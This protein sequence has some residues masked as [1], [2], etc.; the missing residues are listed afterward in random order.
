M[1]TDEKRID[2]KVAEL[3]AQAYRR[4]A[5]DIH[6]EPVKDGF[7]VRLRIDG[8]MQLVPD[9]EIEM[10]PGLVKRVMM[11]SALN[12]ECMDQPQDGRIICRVDGKEIDLRVSALPTIHGMRVTVRLL[13]RSGVM[14]DLDVLGL[15]EDHLAAIKGF[16]HLSHGIV[17][18]TGPT[19]SGKT[20][21]MYS[22]L[23]E[24]DREQC[25]VFSIEDPVEYDLPGVSQTAVR[26][27]SGVTFARAARA[28]LRQDPDVIMIGEIRD[29][30]TIQ[31]AVQVALTGHLVMTQLHASTAPGALVR[32]LDMGMEP[33]LL[34]HAVRG[35]V[36]QRL[37]R[38]LCPKC[39][40]P[41]TPNLDMLPPEAVE[42]VK[43]SSAVFYGPGGCENCGMSGYR[44]RSAINEVITM[45]DEIR[46]AVSTKDLAT[47]RK[48]AVASGM[49][50]LLED[51][52]LRAA[53][54]ETSICEVLRVA[55]V[56]P[57]E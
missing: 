7:Q 48:A 18:C 53:K 1:E 22:M 9:I 55:I 46:A 26:P 32:L 10:G 35:I 42:Q 28:I 31:I 34:N 43:M 36:S 25:A 24:I 14:L 37:V 5:S 47:I 44:G 39:R 21:T 4:R 45:N 50:T 38:R 27:S 52:I 57:F 6:F 13:D 3:I 2:Q 15:P 33:F 41:E 51:G 29:L 54:G 49:R 16:C 11:M 30:E 40:K 20:T 12:T 23:N 56:S 17:L 8:V 19:G